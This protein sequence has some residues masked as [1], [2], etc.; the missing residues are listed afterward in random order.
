M[1]LVCA[2]FLKLLIPRNKNCNFEKKN[3]TKFFL[4]HKNWTY[5]KIK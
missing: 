1:L 5:F 3:K 2:Y 4:K